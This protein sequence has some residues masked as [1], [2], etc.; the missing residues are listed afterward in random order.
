MNAPAAVVFP[1]HSTFMWSLAVSS[2]AVGGPF[3][4]IAGGTMANKLGRR[5]RDS[6]IVGYCGYILEIYIGI[7]WRCIGDILEIYWDI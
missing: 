6:D 3:G 4:A 5:G 7:Y 2:F 1:G